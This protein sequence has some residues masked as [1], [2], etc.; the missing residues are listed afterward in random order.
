MTATGRDDDHEA[1]QNREI[2]KLRNRRMHGLGRIFSDRS[3]ACGAQEQ[4]SAGKLQGHYV[5]T[6]QGSNL[7]YGAF[8]FDGGGT[9]HWDV[10]VTSDG[11]KG[12]MIRT[13]SGTTGVR[14]F[15]Q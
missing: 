7:H 13:D 1:E 6:G 8:D 12:Q 2:G 9:A 14:T 4:R 15:E 5:F 11:K 3:I 10:F